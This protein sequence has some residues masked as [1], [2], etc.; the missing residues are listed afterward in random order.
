MKSRVE[1][2]AGKIADA[3]VE[4]AEHDVEDMEDERL[5]REA[6]IRD[7]GQTRVEGPISGRRDWDDGFCAGSI[8]FSTNGPQGGDAGHGGFLRVTFR[9]IVATCIEVAVNDETAEPADVVAITFRGDAEIRA[10]IDS[11]NFP[12][13]LRNVE[14]IWRL[15]QP[16]S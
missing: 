16:G 14:G 8:E 11:I 2:L 6:E 9:N 7:R 10:L 3:I 12:A 15:L 1:E 13:K 5:A 4:L